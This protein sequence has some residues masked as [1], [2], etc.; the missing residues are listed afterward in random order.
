MHS[1]AQPQLLLFAKRGA[2]IAEMKR[3]SVWHS[4]STPE[5]IEGHRD[6]GRTY[7]GNLLGYAAFAQHRMVMFAV[8]TL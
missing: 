2:C 7:Q 4:N 6:P 3:N 5:M 8:L 1:S